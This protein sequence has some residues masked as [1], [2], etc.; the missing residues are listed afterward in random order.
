VPGRIRSVSEIVTRAGAVVIGA[1]LVAMLA[2]PSVAGAGPA[3]SLPPKVK[4]QGAG[5]RAS[6]H[7]VSPAILRA[8]AGGTAVG[9]CGG[10]DWEP[11]VAT[12][13]SGAHVYVVWAHFPGDTTCDP[14]SGNPNRIYI[15]ASSDGGLTFG[16]AHVVA[17]S[18]D[19]LTYP[20]QVDCVVTVD[21]VTGT[22]YVSFL[23]YGL[24]GN[25][26]TNVAVAKSTDLGQTFTAHKI[27]RGCTNCDHPWTAAR[28]GVV[29]SA[30]DQ[31]KAHYIALSTD[32]G[33]TWAESLAGSF[34]VVAFAEG[35]VFDSAGNAYFAW[36]DCTTSSCTGGTTG[37]YSVS[38]SLG[39][40]LSTTFSH[41]AT[42]PSG[43]SCPYSKC[44][45]AYFG[46]QDDI[47]IDSAG[48]LYV[49]W[50][51]G[52][53]HTQAGSPPIVQLSKSTDGGQT[54]TYVGRADDKAASGCAGSACYAL[55]PRVVASTAGH[56]DVMWMDDRNGVPLDHKNGW[57]VWLRVST[58]GGAS[59]AG[60]SARVSS[61]DPARKESKP[62]GYLFPYGDY[63]DV[64]IAGSTAYLMWGEG[65]NYTGGP[66]NPGHVVYSSMPA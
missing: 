31:G 34:D 50:Q 1:L 64:R 62:S 15:R 32:A 63:E 26:K 56:V 23:I 51:D 60:P 22:V 43:P 3:G 59:W 27:N 52:Q 40:T 65:D 66:S 37:D 25:S 61:Y 47:A 13:P 2:A 5:V 20:S 42:A 46:I 45:F 18:V 29:Y 19:G 17:E 30:Y 53:V 24:G 39:G 10:D 7:A 8:S 28:N 16:P 57:N 49:V 38:K 6:H 41:V 4:A 44:G 58:T 35:A 21:P 33:N 36:G 48:T 12:D 14:A 9:F 11:D 54:W 55:F